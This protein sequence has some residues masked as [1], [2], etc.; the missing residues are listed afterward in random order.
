MSICRAELPLLEKTSAV[1][2]M[3]LT[4]PIANSCS[5]NLEIDHLGN[6]VMVLVQIWIRDRKKSELFGKMEWKLLSVRQGAKETL[7]SGASIKKIN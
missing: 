3:G 5:I 6:F 1:E 7:R 2:I 4:G